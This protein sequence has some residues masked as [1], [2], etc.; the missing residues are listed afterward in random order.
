NCRNLKFT[1]F[2]KPGYRLENRS[3]R[4]IEVFDEDL[5]RLQCYLEPNCVSYNFHKLRQAS[6]THK[7]DLN[8]ATIEHDGKLVENESYIYRGAE[9]A[10]ASNPCRNN[11]TCQAGFT[12]RDY[13]CLCAFGS[14]FE[15][16][17]CDKD[18]DECS[19]ERNGGARMIGNCMLTKDEI[20]HILVG[21]EGKKGKKNLKTAAGGGGTFVVRRNNTPLIIA[22]GGGGIKNMSEQH[23]ACDAS[24][25]TTGNAGNNSPLGSG[26]REGQ[27]GLTNGVNSEG[28]G[29]SGYLQGG[30]GGGFVGG[31]GGGGGLHFSNKGPGGG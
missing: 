11:A 8:N 19:S 27:G 2:P 31:F 6:G 9:N 24:I 12:H 25:N 22:G 14:G 20:I 5:C 18:I 10:C 7:C 16:H 28:E 29:G 13:Q 1:S 15:G 21:Q 23:P 3:V 26:G 4:T 17:D 30:E